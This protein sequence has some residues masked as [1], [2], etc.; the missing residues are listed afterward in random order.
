M[1]N[2]LIVLIVVL[3]GISAWLWF[4][5]YTAPVGKVIVSQSWLDS[6]NAIANKPPVIVY[7][8]TPPP[9]DTV[10]YPVYVP[11]PVKEDSTIVA[12]SDSLVNDQLSVHVFDTIQKG[13]G[14]IL[15]RKWHYRLFVPLKVTETI[16]KTVPM[17]YPIIQPPKTWQYYGT[18]WVGQGVQLEGGAIY[19]GRWKLGTKAGLHSVEIGGGVVF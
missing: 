13:S 18:V 1:K 11:V 16:T 4:R 3:A 19:K 15:S 9:P 8:S 12:Y 7:D 2:V 10:R 5:P 6:L 17:P 14:L